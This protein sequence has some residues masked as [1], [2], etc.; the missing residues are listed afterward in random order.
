MEENALDPAAVIDKHGPGSLR[1]HFDSNAKRYNGGNGANGNGH[2]R[3]KQS[4]R[5]CAFT[6]AELQ[7][8]E[9]KPVDFIVPGL[10]PEGL[11]LFAGRP[12]IGKSWGALDL[13]LGVAGGGC[14]FGGIRPAEGDVLYAAL[15][16]N[17]R[18]LQK[19]LDK[20][21]SPLSTAWPPRLTLATTWRRLDAGGVDDIAEWCHSVSQPKL[22]VLD[23]LAGVR[24]IRTNN[25]YAE[26]YDALTSAHRL[27]NDLG[28]A[29]LVLHHTRKMEAEDPLDTVSGTLGLSGCADT[30]LVINRTA[31]GTT[32]YGRGRDVEEFERALDF[33][34][35]T[36]RWRILG[37]ADEVHRSDTRRAILDV[38]GAD[39]GTM[40]PKDI[41]VACNMDPNAVYQRLHRM[42]PDGDVIKDGHGKYR[43]PAATGEA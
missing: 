7:K 5:D 29:I 35:D 13:C 36:C 22:V 32:L 41:A 14:V 21:S 4:W 31:Q 42:V 1:T 3:S 40:T 12:K 17:P 37:N 38:L 16:D 30:V 20:L 23:T 6:A 10:L 2:A 8:R 28:I 19:R 15:E 9:F 27:A 11:T 43:L 26:D 39:G 25:G 33:N 34:K 18:R 24:P